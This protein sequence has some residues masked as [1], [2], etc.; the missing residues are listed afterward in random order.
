VDGAVSEFLRANDIA[1]PRARECLSRGTP[2]IFDGNF[3][4]EPQIKD[5]IDRLDFRNFAFT[6]R[7]PLEICVAR[8]ATRESPFGETAATEVYAKT[9]R[10]AW[11]TDVDA[12]GRPETVLAEILF[13]LA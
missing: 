10:V 12:S 3:Y 6:L 9:M 7:A 1:V 11:G 4:W 5:L 2:V 8:D 13:H